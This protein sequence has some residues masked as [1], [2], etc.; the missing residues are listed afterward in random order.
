[1]KILPAH[2]I[3]ATGV[4]PAP[5]ITRTGIAVATLL[6]TLCI[7]LPTSATGME[8]TDASPSA[9]AAEPAM[10]TA[11]TVPD[12]VAGDASAVAGAFDRGLPIAL[13]LVFLLGLALN[14]T[15]CVY[16]MLA[17]T[18]SIF[19]GQTD[20]RASR[21]FGKALLYVLGIAS[22]YSILGVA[23]ALTGGLFGGLLQSRILLL[24]IGA[25]FILLA[26][27][28]FGLYELR[29]PDRVMARLGGAGG[30]GLAGIFLSGLLVGVFAAP[31]IGPPI[32]A[33]LALVGQRSDPWFGFMVFFVLS[34]GLGLP[35]LILGT[36]SGLLRKMPRS[37]DW[38]LWVK[39]LFGIMLLGVAA[40][41]A[42]LALQPSLALFLISL[43]MAGGGLYLG[44]LE[45]SPAGKVFAWFKRLTGTAA[46]AGAA[47]LFAVGLRPALD[48]TEYADGPEPATGRAAVLYFSADWCIPCLELDR[49]TFTDARVIRELNRLDRFKV[50]LTRFDSPESRHIRQQFDI[51]GVPTMVFLD[52]RGQELAG[53]RL[54]G[55]VPARD[56]LDHL[57]Q[58][59]ASMGNGQESMPAAAPDEADQPSQ[60]MLVADV[61]WIQPGQPFN[62]GILFLIEDQWHVYWINPGDSGMEPIISWQLPEGFTAGEVEWPHPIRFDDPP[63]ATFGYEEELLLAR[64]I[65]PPPDLAAG[66]TVELSADLEWQV[67]KDIC[68]VQLDR[69]SLKLET[70]DETPPPADKQP[71]FVRA[72]ESLPR[73]D[74]AWQFTVTAE[75]EAL[76][77]TAT[78]PPGVSP[79][80]I[81]RSGFFPSQP[82][83]LRSGPYRWQREAEQARLSL[84]AEGPKPPD[85]VLRGVLVPPRPAVERH[86]LPRAITIEAP[87]PGP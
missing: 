71:F 62:A 59:R 87:L 84:V 52:S 74:P 1:M 81:T 47:F 51:R 15:P 30:S 13:L 72:R 4:W 63:F 26:L 60:A 77:L 27:S 40:F 42:S 8:A 61:E 21:V 28:M 73:R 82:G 56:M 5:W 19:G 23:A 85:N 34:L 44:F 29:V 16:P 17:V 24:S 46:I 49:R 41:Y 9:I 11:Q 76:L 66:V 43:I 57:R 22:M 14:L 53:S 36:F 31:C 79:D 33:L 78:P 54:V 70:R 58:V 35:Y 3:P 7:Q 80:I 65:V 45:G 83:F 48:W 20:A 67:C 50:D 10:Q 25:L 32:I 2:N 6:A 18:V 12:G 38:M 64:R 68:I 37:G 55:F 69:V 86:G 39:K 75:N